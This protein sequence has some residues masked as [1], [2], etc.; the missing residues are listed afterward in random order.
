MKKFVSK[1]GYL[2]FI[3]ITAFFFYAFNLRYTYFFSGDMARDTLASL[4]VLKN[5]EI[6]AIGPPLSF[7]QYG[8][9][10]IYFSSLTYYMGA[11]GLLLFN[12]DVLGP[13]YINIFL[14]MIGIYYFYRLARLFFDQK[15][16]LLATAIFSLSPVVVAHLRFFWNPNF[17]ISISP[18]YWYY[19]F[20]AL[21]E[22]KKINYFLSGFLAG[23]LFHFH[24]FVIFAIGISLILLLRKNF[25]NS[26][27][28]ILSFTLSILPLI[29]FEIKNHFYL[30][31]ALI[32]NATIN[33]SFHNVYQPIFSRP[34]IL[35]LIDIFLIPIIF[36]AFQTEATHFPTLFNPSYWQMIIIGL[37]I[38][39]LIFRFFINHKKN[40]TINILIT[41]SFF[42][43]LFSS[44]LAHEVYYLRYFFIALPLLTTILTYV[45]DKRLIIFLI[46]SLYLVTD[47]R[48]LYSQKVHNDLIK[49]KNTS[50]PTIEQM[51]QVAKLIKKEKPKES[52][53]ITENFIGDARAL[54]LRF[55]LEKDNEIKPAENEINYQ[56]LK[57]L[58]VFAPNLN[59]VYK[60]N[61]WEFTATPNLKLTK[62]WE[63]DKN[64]YLFKFERN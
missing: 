43:A 58:F 54:Y 27:F 37:I 46:F 23:F 22:N 64:K 4:R 49:V 7:G 11:L 48:I 33:R 25:K 26:M 30:T 28:F 36:L 55:F 59:T 50:Y 44:L 52:Y 13:V 41:I 16:S 17:T 15:K 34:I 57:T 31:N 38:Y 24:Y 1:N 12:K 60:E 8:T 10:E 20:I 2:I 21:K 9:R 5:K 51:E 18:I 53:N 45:L 40:T 47:L 39:L 61:R 32:Y 63:I 14:M 35:K 19:Y 62:T 29:L 42:T 6:T 56:N 3:M